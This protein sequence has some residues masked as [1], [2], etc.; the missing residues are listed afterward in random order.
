MACAVELCNG[1]DD[2]SNGLNDYNSALLSAE[3]FDTFDAVGLDT[4]T[5]T[6]VLCQA[7]VITQDG[8]GSLFFAGVRRH[9]EDIVCHQGCASVAP[10]TRALQRHRV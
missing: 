7:E 8:S 6:E 5:W 4:G 3:V 9:L 10:E 1:V 2:D